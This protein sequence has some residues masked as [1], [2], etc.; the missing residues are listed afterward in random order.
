MKE[1]ETR[2]IDI[3]IDEIRYKLVQIGAKKV[4]QENQINN[5]YDFPDNRLIKNKGYARI[6]YIKD[7]INN[8]EI[9]Y[10]TVKKLLSQNKFK[11]MDENEIK[12]SNLNEGKNIFS[13][14]GLNLVQ[15]IK[16]YRESYKYKNTLIEIDINDPSFCPFPYI[17]LETNNEDELKEVVELLGY[18]I[19]DTTSKTI[20]EILKIKSGE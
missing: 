13:A 16:K 3:N 7:L 8:K 14:L 11:V 5:I 19:N 15:C 1:L 10:M 20:Y 4:K 2:I 18:T 12:I 17:E 6:R 9:Y